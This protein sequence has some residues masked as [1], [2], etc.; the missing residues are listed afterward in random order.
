MRASLSASRSRVRCWGSYDGVWLR[1]AIGEFAG[2]GRIPSVRGSTK[3]GRSFARWRMAQAFLT[4]ANRP[5]G[6]S[7]QRARG[8]TE[9]KI[10]HNMTYVKNKSRVS[11]QNFA[12]RDDIYNKFNI[13]GHHQHV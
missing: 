13:L 7:P 12:L 8:A 6:T 2:G 5:H 9:G 1:S 4:L 11:E 10:I 3:P